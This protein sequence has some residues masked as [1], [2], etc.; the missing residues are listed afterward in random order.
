MNLRVEVESYRRRLSTPLATRR[1][2]ISERSGFFVRLV[3]SDG[4][5]GEG[6]AAPVYWID[7]DPIDTV[8]RYLAALADRSVA[9]EAMESAD[10]VR[11]S[12]A[13]LTT[14]ARVRA[15]CPAAHA[16]IETAALDL[17]SRRRGMA[18]ATLLGGSAHTPVAVNALVVAAR[19]ADVAIDVK[20]HVA[21]GVSVVKLKVGAGE[22]AL[23]V[24]RVCA[25]A[26]G[27]QGKARLRLDANRA[28]SFPVAGRILMAVA[29]GVIDYVEEPLAS[30]SATELSRLRASTAVAIAVDESLEALG[31]IAALAASAACD[32]IVLKPARVG[33]PL[34]TL[35]LAHAAGEHGLRCVLTDS[36]ET[37]VGRA[38]VVHTAA[39]LGGGAEAV[40]LGGR[41]LLDDE[42]AHPA[43]YPCGP[44]LTVRNESWQ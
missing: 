41:G 10:D 2:A 25:A 31:G 24:E 29:S 32:V 27:T 39:A 23:D 14:V 34:R 19:P 9:V 12:V 43:L 30:P 21:R 37:E 42:P 20:R 40:G 6:E 17:A 11:A 38:A 26:E 1:G 16:A 15:P 5:V 18:V 22:P 28:W 4:Q 35:A 13:A 8:G 36:I 3:D 7:D 33:G 44:G